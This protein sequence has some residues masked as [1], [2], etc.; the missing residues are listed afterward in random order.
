MIVP[1][2]KYGFTWSRRFWRA[3]GFERC[4]AWSPLRWNLMLGPLMVSRWR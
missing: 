1:W 4:P 2:S 3:W